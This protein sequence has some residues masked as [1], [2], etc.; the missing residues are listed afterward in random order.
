M[1]VPQAIR[2]VNLGI[3]TGKIV[4]KQE[5]KKNKMMMMMTPSH[6]RPL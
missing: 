5:A 4:D 6:P 3:D 1:K 2:P